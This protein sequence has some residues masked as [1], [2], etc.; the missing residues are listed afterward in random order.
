V[1]ALQEF[2]EL[3]SGVGAV[4]KWVHLKTKLNG[5][6][7]QRMLMTHK[8]QSCVQFWGKPFVL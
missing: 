4:A 6:K 1:A 8:R 2:A 3:S 5:Q 7:I